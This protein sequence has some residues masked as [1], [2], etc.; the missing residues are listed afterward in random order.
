VSLYEF[1][2]SD[3]HGISKILLL[4]TIGGMFAYPFDKRLTEN[5][6]LS[7][8]KLMALPAK[9]LHF[10]GRQRP[11]NSQINLI[12]V[13]V[14]EWMRWI[15]RGHRSILVEFSCFVLSVIGLPA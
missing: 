12:A 4:K 5:L 6:K 9:P 13:L 15:A 14:P 8:L 1:F 10:V 11:G 2:Q 3:P 7:K